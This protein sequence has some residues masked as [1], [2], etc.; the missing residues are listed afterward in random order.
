MDLDAPTCD[1]D[2]LDDEAQ[3]SLPSGEVEIVDP[4]SRP[5]GEVLH[6]LSQAVLG[7]KLAAS[8]HQLVALSDEVDTPG[9]HVVQTPS[10]LWKLDHGALV[11]VK[12]TA[13]FGLGG[14]DLTFESR[15]LGGQ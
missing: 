10:E 9:L 3:K 5:R 2:A 6:P 11:A 12:Q 15:Q 14:G 7:R 4:R 8:S 13:F 1:L